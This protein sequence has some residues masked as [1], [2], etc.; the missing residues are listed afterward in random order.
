MSPVSASGSRPTR[1]APERSCS[2]C[3]T[4]MYCATALRDWQPVQLTP[5]TI[6]SERVPLT[7]LARRSARD[8][9]PVVS[10]PT[11]FAAGRY[12][13]AVKPSSIGSTQCCRLGAPGAEHDLYLIFDRPSA[14]CCWTVG[15]HRPKDLRCS[16]CTTRSRCLRTEINPRPGRPRRPVRRA[17]RMPPRH[18]ARS[19]LGHPGTVSRWHCRLVTKKWTTRRTCRST[20]RRGGDAD[21]QAHQNEVD[22]AGQPRPGRPAALIGDKARPSPGSWIC[23]TAACREDGHEDMRRSCSAT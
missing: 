21:E 13:P 9:S 4:G 19:S 17:A 5:Y 15:Q 18:A 12:R 16:S 20:R 11:S 6:M 23:G 22:L 2:P 3:S 14:G 8:D 7:A 1:P 10:P